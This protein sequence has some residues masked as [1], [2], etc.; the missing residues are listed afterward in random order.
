MTFWSVIVC[1]IWRRRSSLVIPEPAS[2][3]SK[4]ASLFRLYCS[5][6]RSTAAWIS[7]SVA[8]TDI[9]FARSSSRCSLIMSSS[10][11]IR[12]SSVGAWTLADRV[13]SARRL[14]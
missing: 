2:A 6:T 4:S 11:E 10:V 7:S 9:S 3:A 5:L 1:F 12:I 8:D 14:S 13:A